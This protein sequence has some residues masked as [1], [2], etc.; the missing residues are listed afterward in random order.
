VDALASVNLSDIEAT[1]QVTVLDNQQA[2]IHVGELTPIRTIDAGATGGGAGFPTAQVEQQ[3]TGV[4]LTATPHV[5]ADGHIL[6]EVEAER[7]AAELAPSDA[8]FIF[9]TQRVQT[10][11]LLRDGETTVMGGLT[12][13]EHT[14]A[15]SGIPLLQDLP[16]IGRLFRVVREQEIQQDLI[17]LVT[18]N[19]VRSSS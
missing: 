16:L 14:E 2:I 9:R 11:V 17:I 18:P 15:R 5:T 7:S 12:Q 8:G 4:I 3:E 13:A 19:I 1:P 10:R 6:L